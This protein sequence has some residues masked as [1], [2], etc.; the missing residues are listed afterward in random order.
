MKAMLNNP[1]FLLL[2]TGT[3]VGLYFPLGKVASEAGISSIA[4]AMVLSIG[5]CIVLLPILAY[6][7]S[8]AIPR[9]A[10]LRYVAIAG[11][12]SFVT[13]NVLLFSV[14]P[15]VGAGYT[16]LMFALSPVFT[17]AVAL[18]FKLKGPNLYGLIGITL[19]CIG[20]L[21]IACARGS[22]VDAPP[23]FW[24][25]AALFIPVVLASANVYRTIDWPEDGCPD[26]LAFWSHLFSIAVLFT[27]L[28]SIEGT[29]PIYELYGAAMLTITQALLAG[30]TFPLYFRLQRYG[31][32]VLLS[33]LGYVAA[34]VGMLVA[35]IILGER[36]EFFIWAGSV[37]IVTGIAATV[38]SQLSIAKEA[39]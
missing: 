11:V 18:M 14:I 10:T 33:Q 2:T 8:F 35:T 22:I 23:V 1:V 36:Y 3:L 37:V 4:W 13:P 7:R 29:Q 5:A 32:P 6:K 39:K 21:I 16:G 17:L 34:A 38:Y 9:G 20:A 26:S 31:G 15:Y 30:L 12:I 19:G 28:I 24:I 27:L 25:V